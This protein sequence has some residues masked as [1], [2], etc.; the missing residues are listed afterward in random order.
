MMAVIWVGSRAWLRIIMMPKSMLIPIVLVLCVIGAYALSNSMNDVYVLALFCVHRLR[1]GEGAH[2]ARA[3]DPR[4]RARRPD[5]GQPDPGD[6]DQRQSVAVPDAADFRR[7]A[8]RSRSLSVALAVWQH[9]REAKRAA[10]ATRKRTPT[11]RHA[12]PPARA[13]IRAQLR[14]PLWK[15]LRSNFSF[16]ECT[17]SSSSAKPTMSESMPEH[18]LEVRDDR[19][20]AAGADRHRLLAPLLRQARRAP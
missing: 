18:A 20:R 4:R 14:M 7:P 1:D 5:R 19:D 2:S 10:R 15:H 9:N 11:S 13:R 8:R 3:A 16:G 12:M 17:R 6:V